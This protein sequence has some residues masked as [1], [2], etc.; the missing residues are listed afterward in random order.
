MSASTVS[1]LLRSYTP[2]AFRPQTER[3]LVLVLGSFASIIWL[4]VIPIE[5]V[6]SI[7]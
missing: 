6:A 3:R 2:L 7:I 1:V 5:I 4:L